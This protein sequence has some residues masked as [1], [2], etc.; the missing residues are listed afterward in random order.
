M[1]NRNSDYKFSYFEN[2]FTP[3]P[4]QI[5]DV[6]QLIEFIKYPYLK[7][8]LDRLRALDKV[9]YKKQKLSLPNVTLSGIFPERKNLSLEQHSGLMQIDFD[10]IENYN[11]TREALINDQYTYVLFRSPSGNGI[12]MLVKINPLQETHKGQFLALENYYLEEY[13]L[14]M[15]KGTKDVSRAMLLSYDPHLYCNPFAEIFE[16]IL[17]EKKY[18]RSQPISNEVNET[19]ALY[20]R[21]NSFEGREEYLVNKLCTNIKN[22]NIDLTDSHANWISVGFILSN[23]FGESGRDYFHQL[24]AHHPEY[25]YEKCDAKYSQ[26]HKDNN[27]GLSFGTLVFMARNNGIEIFD[28]E[29]E[30]KTSIKPKTGLRE[31]LKK[32]RLEI[33][34]SINKPTF[35]VFSNKTL[36]DLI[37]KMPKSKNELEEVYGFGKQKINLYSVEFLPIIKKFVEH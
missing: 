31:A 3:N 17:E 7:S 25:N 19:K 5:I 22:T 23:T 6:N 21:V 37:M 28:G 29:N 24:S 9:E 26:L 12:K 35:T 16:E 15:D 33:A 11:E 34:N 18:K 32:K 4:S 36:D 1:K 13:N 8:E 10:D 2:L 14:Q 20:K 27:G 30:T